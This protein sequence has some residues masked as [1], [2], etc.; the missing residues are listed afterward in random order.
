MMRKDFFANAVSGLAG[1]G[2]DAEVYAGH[3]V[4]LFSLVI[5]ERIGEEYCA[6]VKEA[7]GDRMI[8]ALA[9]YYRT[10]KDSGVCELG[11]ARSADIEWAD[12][13][14]QGK[15]REVNIDWQ[16]PDGEIDFMFDPTGLLGVV[17]HEWQWQLNRHTYWANLAR[18]YEMTKKAVYAQAFER[19]L[20]K[21]IAQTRA[22]EE[23]NVPV[24]AWRT[25]ECG[26]RLLGSWQAAFDGFKKAPE[27]SDIA[28]LLMIASMHRQTVH[29]V[30][31]P[32]TGNWLMMEANGVY[33]FSALFTEL[34]DSGSHR[35]KAAGWLLEELQ[36]QTL[37]DGMHNELS[38]DYQSVVFN[39]ASNFYSLAKSLGLEGEIPET[40]PELIERTTH[41]AI[42]LSTPALTQPRTNDCYTIPTEKFAGRTA[43]MFGP[44]SEYV[45]IT[46]KRA[47]GQPP[48]GTTASAFL[49]YA[50]FA[51][52][53]SDWSENASYLCFDVGPL[54]KNHMHQD[55]LNIIL[56]QGE[57]ELIYDDGGGQY[58]ISPAR[59]YALSGY[60]HNT[61]LVDGLA[62]NRKGPLVL[63]EPV[64]AGWITNESFDYAYGIYDG[65]FGE[66]GVTPVIHKREIRFCKPGF[67]CVNDILTPT[68]GRKHDYEVLF[69]LDAEVIS[70]T[71]QYDNG[72][73]AEYDKK[74]GLL[75]IPL[76]QEEQKTEVK[77]V[78]GQTD[79]RWQGWYNGRNE[80]N[81][82]RAMTVSRIVRDT[83][84][85]RFTT[86][87]FPVCS[88]SGERTLPEVSCP[89]E[90]TVK[91]SMQGKEYLLDLC[92]LNR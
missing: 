1:N 36:I 47:E 41:A 32:T 43:D 66:E 83:G 70:D 35:E 27:V 59:R 42:L 28:L 89:D 12:R 17:N 45:Y 71:E 84:E 54:G 14:V 5:P 4:E 75:M 21:W 50:G 92:C 38:P 8:K 11:G 22:G 18:V 13:T 78:S 73:M 39:C 58:E 34:A 56:Y 2:Q 7:D 52:M 53:R 69:H 63:E 60:G 16:F 87:L 61:V 48:E 30:Q 72:I 10:K 88:L 20:L 64:D 3:L 51:V 15:M 46:S 24:S 62:Q 31:H 40:I 6:A 79:P 19:Q 74:Y 82:H 86:L 29:L 33:T 57:Q 9:A 90:R 44:K 76:D 68:D 85:Y 55:K 81:L 77:V 67:F 65:A 91:V 80:S 49:P 23:W 26:I 37:P 25:I